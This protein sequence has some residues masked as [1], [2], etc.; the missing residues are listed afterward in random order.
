MSHVNK[1]Y[2][3]FIKFDVI[4][5]KVET[6]LNIWCSDEIHCPIII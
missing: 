5:S 6:G 4:V 1:K 3:V 2:N